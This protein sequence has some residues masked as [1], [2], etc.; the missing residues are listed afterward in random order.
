VQ[1]ERRVVIVTGAGSGIGR[2]L[3]ESFAYADA[4]VVVADIDGAR[5]ND[6]ADWIA[7]RGYIAVAQ[8]ADAAIERDIV[9]LIDLAA[10]KFGP[11]DIYVANAGITGPFGLGIAE[12]DWD[13]V[14]EVN[15]RAHT[16]AAAILVPGWLTR[17]GGHFVSIASAVGLLNQV[18]AAAYV[19]SKHAA[20]GFAEWLAI[21]YGDSGIGVSCVCPMGVNTNMFDAL[22][23]STDPAAQLVR[24]AIFHAAGTVEPDL[25]AQKTVEAVRS[26]RFLVLPQSEVLEMYRNKG[27]DY[28]RWVRAM[29]S[30]Q[31]S[32]LPGRDDL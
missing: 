20:I 6:T 12:H 26:E 17:G 19:V 11:V 32:L 3:A 28:D 8:Q 10:E 22:R 9:A 7:Q 15:L 29:R 30:Y 25:V 16:R 31:R 4:K 1:I 13:R 21:A 14:L 24:R 23:T 5:A 18:A 2:A 27:L